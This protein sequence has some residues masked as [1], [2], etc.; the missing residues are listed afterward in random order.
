M[1]SLSSTVSTSQNYLSYPLH[2]S[3]GGMLHKS[4]NRAELRNVVQTT[5]GVAEVTL[6]NNCISVDTNPLPTE[7]ELGLRGRS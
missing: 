5:T 7:A 6:R 1:S 3:C 4:E 2:C